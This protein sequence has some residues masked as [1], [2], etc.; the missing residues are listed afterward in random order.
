MG[1]TLKLRAWHRAISWPEGLA[2]GHGHDNV[3]RMNETDAARPR[4]PDPT[5]SPELFD[6]LLTR[7]TIAFLID[8]VAMGTLI[9]GFTLLGLIAGFLT[10]GLAWLGLFIVVPASIVFYYAVTLGSARRATIGMQLMDLVLTPV[11]GQPLDGWM[12]LIHAGVFWLTAWI[13][14]PL[15]LLFTLFTP[16]RQMLHDLV[17]G[18]LM[19]RRSPMIRHWQ[20]QKLR[21]TQAF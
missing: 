19:V 14:L 15:S 10:F 17:T 12:A 9:I 21:A 11:R 2:Q 18:T 6:G 8:L 5:S 4:L 16:R 3:L 1:E 13:S 7:R 20:A